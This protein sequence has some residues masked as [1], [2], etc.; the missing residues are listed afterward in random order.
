VRVLITGAA[1]V[2][3]RAA[4][5]ALAA[6]H[7]LLLLDRWPQQQ[8]DGVP[9][10]ADI[11]DWRPVRDAL[12][13]HGPIDA[14]VHL[15]FART[16][17]E[18]TAE[19]QAILQF[20]VT[21]RGTWIVLHEA[22]R[23]GAQRCVFASSL[24]VYGHRDV[25]DAL[26]E[27][28]DP[29]TFTNVDDYGLAK[30]LAENVVRHFAARRGM[31]AVVLRLAAVHAPGV[32]E[33]R[34]THVEDV[35]DAI[36]RSLTFDGEPFDVFNLVPDNPEWGASNTKAK[37]LLGWHPQHTFDRRPELANWDQPP[38]PPPDATGPPIGAIGSEA[39]TS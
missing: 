34:G 24:S 9:I 22:Q 32:M 21:A 25:A 3:G 33:R 36:R 38:Q 17:D 11:T 7:E 19:E 28:D 27:T 29:F 1:G 23:L 31:R 26:D 5:D 12:E 35:A 6:D 4:R 18:L 39:E 8:T 10:Q 15:A 14:V 37:T 30:T 13:P 20:D 2:V 16:Y